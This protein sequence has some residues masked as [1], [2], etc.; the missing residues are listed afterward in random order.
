MF[1]NGALNPYKQPLNPIAK[2]YLEYQVNDTFN[3]KVK[4]YP[5]GT[6]NLTICRSDIFGRDERQF[7]LHSQAYKDFKKTVNPFWVYDDLAY[8]DYQ[9]NNVLKQ[10]EVFYKSVDNYLLFCQEGRKIDKMYSH[11]SLVWGCNAFDDSERAFLNSLRNNI[12]KDNLKKSK[13]T[14]FDLV[15]CNEWSYFFTG[16]IDS[17]KY[18]SKNASALK[19]KLRKW[20]ENMVNRYHISYI[21]IFEYHKKGGIH[22][23]GLIHENPLFPL[24][25]VDSGTKS[26]YGFKKPMRDS[27][28]IKHGLDVSKGHIV[29]NLSTWKFGFSTAIRCYGSQNS[30]SSYMTKY[31]TKS[32]VKIM[33][34]YFWHSRDLKRP[35]ITY[36][37]TP[38]YDN[39]PIP[40]YHGFKYLYSPQGNKEL[41]QEYED[42]LQDSEIRENNNEEWI[43]IL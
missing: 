16:T 11:D 19:P 41:Y 27:T 32:N 2:K 3:C 33:G 10:I 39:L 30:L 9:R 4:T 36:I 26:Y 24:R 13:D 5:N 28:A 43:D 18:D 40:T 25:L 23:H 35:Q 17:K 21:C 14:I 6:Q 34:R 22:L 38:D 12:R 8:Q 15:M 42:I 29:Y 1:K 7:S 20:F 37:N 31:I